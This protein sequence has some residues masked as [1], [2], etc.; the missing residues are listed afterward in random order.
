WWV[1]VALV[2]TA[3][4]IAL[5]LRASPVAPSTGER[6]TAARE[7]L[8]LGGR[9]LAV[10]EPGSALGWRVDA[11][12]ARIEPSAGDVGYRAEKGGPFVVRTPA[13]EVRVRGTCFRVEVDPMKKGFLQMGAGAAM[14]TAV[15]V[16]VY[17][18]KVIL[19][20]EKGQT[21]LA[22]GQQ[23]RVASGESPSAASD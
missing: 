17:E 16:T 12:A 5:A 21:A 20:N 7:T 2:A 8:P 10:A 3:A 14:A 1:G 15:L 11:G 9:G 19:A 6:I 18:G 22:A 23:A 4:V 13:G